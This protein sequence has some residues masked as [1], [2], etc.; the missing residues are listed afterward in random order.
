M[1][2]YE[3]IP[4]ADVRDSDFIHI[5]VPADIDRATIHF[6]GGMNFGAS[7][8]I[9]GEYELSGWRPIPELPEGI[10]AVV[11]PHN[12]ATAVAL[13]IDE[14]GRW[15]VIRSGAVWEREAVEDLLEAG[16]HYVAFE[17]VES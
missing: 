15:R 4:L 8:T 16:T 14:D 12:P 7:V 1:T 11:M 10:G 13:A 5:L 6:D 9:K 17:G 2:K 3:T